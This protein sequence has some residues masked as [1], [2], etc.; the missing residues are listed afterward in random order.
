MVEVCMCVNLADQHLNFLPAFKE[1]LL[2]GIDG[3]LEA[4]NTR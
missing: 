2:V 3:S 4:K 1:S